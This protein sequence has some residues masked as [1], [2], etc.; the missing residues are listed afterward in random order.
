MNRVVAEWVEKAEGDHVSALRELR[1]RKNPNYDSACFHAQ[2]CAEKYIKG[3]LQAW[4]VPFSKTHD[5]AKLLDLCVDRHPEWELF[6]E[7]FKLLTQYAVVFRYPGESATKDEAKQAVEVAAAIRAIL[8]PLLQQ[9][10]L[11]P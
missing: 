1:A 6:R 4:Q 9:K 10:G 8:R 3:I 11:Q 5:L 7:D 2:Q